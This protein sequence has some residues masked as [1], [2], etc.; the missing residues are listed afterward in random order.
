MPNNQNKKKNQPNSWLFFT[1]LGLQ[2]GVTVY[3]MAYLGDILVIIGL[4]AS[5]YSAVKQLNKINHD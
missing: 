4:V 2:I 5:I 3:V 1:G